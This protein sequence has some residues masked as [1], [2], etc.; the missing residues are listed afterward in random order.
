MLDILLSAYDLE[1]SLLCLVL[2]ELLVSLTAPPIARF[3]PFTEVS[4][5]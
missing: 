2:L 1:P 4:H 3:N 5:Y